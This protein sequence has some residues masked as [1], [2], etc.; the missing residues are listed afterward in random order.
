MGRPSTGK[1]QASSSRIVAGNYSFGSAAGSFA[2]VSPLSYLAEF[3]DTS[4]VSNPT[5]VVTFKNLFKKDS[6]TKT[7]ALEDLNLTISESSEIEDAI[8]DVWAAIYPRTSVESSRRVRQLAHTIQGQICVQAGKRIIK[9]LPT[10]VGP[11][12][13]GLYDNDKVVSHAAQ[14]ALNQAFPSQE[15][16]KTLLQRYQSQILSQC[17]SVISDET[18]QTLSDE[19][20]VSPDEA[21]AKYDR[22]LAAAIGLFAHMINIMSDDDMKICSEQYRNLIDEKKLWGLVS[23]GDPFVRRQVNL[24]LRAI[25]QNSF[26]RPLQ[27]RQTISSSFIAKGLESD[28][29]G[30]AVSFLETLIALTQWEPT[31]W[32]SEWNNKKSPLHRLKHFV[33]GGSHSS[34]V[35]TYWAKLNSFLKGLPPALFSDPKEVEEFLQ[36]FEKGINSKDEPKYTWNLGLYGLLSALSFVSLHLEDDSFQLETGRKI[37]EPIFDSYLNGRNSSVSSA[38]VGDIIRIVFRMRS[39]TALLGQIINKVGESMLMDL[40]STLPEQ[41]VSQRAERWGSLLRYLNI[42]IGN[43]NLVNGILAKLISESINICKTQNGDARGS[44]SLLV[45]LVKGGK[46]FIDSTPELSDQLNSFLVHEM[47]EIFVS[48]S[49]TQFGELLKLVNSSKDFSVIWI[50]CLQSSRAVP[51]D[52][53]RRLAYCSLIGSLQNSTLESSSGDASKIYSAMDDLIVDILQSPS[54]SDSSESLLAVLLDIL[55]FYE[56]KAVEQARIVRGIIERIGTG[57]DVSIAEALSFLRS[58]KHPDSK[59]RSIFSTTEADRFFSTLLCWSESTE[60]ELKRASSSCIDWI[61][62]HNPFGFIEQDSFSS[63]LQIELNKASEDSLLVS[64]LADIA[65]KLKSR[66]RNQTSP[67]LLDVNSWRKSLEPFLN[68]PPP[69]SSCITSPLRGAVLLVEQ[70][71]TEE[72]I[73]PYDDQKWSVPFRIAVYTVEVLEQMEFTSEDLLGDNFSLILELLT[74]TTII[75]NENISFGVSRLGPNDE[76]ELTKFVSD[77]FKLIS[78]VVESM[79]QG[80]ENSESLHLSASSDSVNICVQ[81]LYDASD[82]RSASAYRHALACNHLTNE[83]IERRRISRPFEEI[84]NKIMSLRKSAKVS[85]FRAISYLSEYHSFLGKSQLAIRWYNE[86]MAD[87]T[88]P[89][90]LN[91]PTITLDRLVLMH[92]LIKDQDKDF[93]SGA[94]HQ[95]VVLFIRGLVGWLDDESTPPPVVIV[96]QAIFRELAPLLVE[97]YGDHW[98]TIINF[99]KN[100]WKGCSEAWDPEN[101]GNEEILPLLYESIKL[102]GVLESIST[103]PDCNEDLI[104]ALETHAFDLRQALFNLLMMERVVDEANHSPLRIVNNLICRRLQNGPMTE[105]ITEPKQMY[106][107]LVTKSDAIQTTAFNILHTNIPTLQEELSME[108]ALGSDNVARLPDELLS[109]I[110]DAPPRKDDALMDWLDVSIV[111]D[112]DEGIPS[113][114]RCYLFSWILVFDHFIN[115]VR[116]IKSFDTYNIDTNGL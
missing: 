17:S 88:G 109:L 36:S 69:M 43:L 22:V 8:I 101:K 28:Q 40:K 12:L 7:R 10:V 1:V 37:L 84:S 91:D 93:V 15:K 49:V 108:I 20:I 31:I 38:V 66:K 4:K 80:L 39:G 73:I 94:A 51:W 65:K 13:L 72:P 19:R 61:I 102:I 56:R 100:L 60:D 27:N 115:A 52:E 55:P 59:I 5:T 29:K 92:A 68:I 75:A 18:A 83:L 58:I 47:P 95:R 63:L 90:A 23:S 53:T 107:L 16:R 6:T 42:E 99:I 110:V 45:E 25:I 112:Y 106:S 21:I 2:S 32:T 35:E 111:P 103:K 87:L 104:E 82:N 67:F 54:D 33:R 34:S 97:I 30:T 77:S 76:F 74:L 48:R 14:E 81:H 26:T 50:A 9:Y 86:M 96:A 98:E 11:W 44:A 105:L 24:L 46:Q 113:R 116:A 85:P 62:S 57:S 78:K 70:S 71:Q 89:G 79:P 64:T 3:P 41:T 114:L